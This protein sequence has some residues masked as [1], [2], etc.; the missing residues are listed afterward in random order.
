MSTAKAKSARPKSATRKK[1]AAPQ[2]GLNDAL[3]EAA[4]AEADAALAEALACCD[5][6]AGADSEEAREAAWTLLDQALS[7]AARKRGLSRIGKLGARE[8][9]DSKRHDVIEPVT[10]MPKTVRVMAR[11]VVRGRDVLVKTRVG[12]VRKQRT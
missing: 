12:A 8:A 2:A 3:A 6:A 9:Y 5:E 7:R 11:G 10:R 4:W 1:R